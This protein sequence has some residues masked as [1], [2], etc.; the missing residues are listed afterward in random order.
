MSET[1]IILGSNSYHAVQV[2]GTATGRP[3]LSEAA[4]ETMKRKL[5]KQHRHL[6]F[7]VLPVTEAPA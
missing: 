4:A 2:F 1:W 6:D 3:F 7:L 5:E